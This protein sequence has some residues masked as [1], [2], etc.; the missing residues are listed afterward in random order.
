[1]CRSHRRANFG[2][3]RA[4]R[5]GFTGYLSSL[6]S[7]SRIVAAPYCGVAT[8]CE[9]TL[10]HR[11]P[12]VRLLLAGPSPK[13]SKRPQASSFVIAAVAR[14]T[15]PNSRLFLRSMASPRQVPGL[16]AIQSLSVTQLNSEE[17]FVAAVT[18][19]AEPE[20]GGSSRKA[21]E[22]ENGGVGAPQMGRGGAT[23][24]VEAVK[25]VLGNHN[26]ARNTVEV[27]LRRGDDVARGGATE[28]A[29]PNGNWER[30]RQSSG[31]E[32]DGCRHEAERGAGGG[33]NGRHSH[34]QC[35]GHGHSHAHSSTVVD[36]V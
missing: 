18:V 19:V 10:H 22:L 31:I 16:S 3:K 1:M 17:P 2:C 30:G 29:P 26:I 32:S 12:H 36:M 15:L 28:G 34:G 13:H 14:E 4:V 24:L 23:A 6:P 9:H 11:H 25:R 20:A 33:C 5:Q 7:Y 35:S 27:V 8:P 21:E